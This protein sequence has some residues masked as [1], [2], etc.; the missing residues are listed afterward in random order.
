MADC[1]LILSTANHCKQNKMF[2]RNSDS[3]KQITVMLFY[4]LEVFFTR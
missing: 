4:I 2:F 3:S 1:T